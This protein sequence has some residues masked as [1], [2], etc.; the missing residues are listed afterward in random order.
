MDIQF[1]KKEINGMRKI[2]EENTLCI[3][4]LVTKKDYELKV[5]WISDTPIAFEVTYTR[6]YSNKWENGYID[7]EEETEIEFETLP[8]EQQA[9]ALKL[10]KNELRETI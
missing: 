2:S 3:Y 9:L 6:E 10:Y 8:I 4:T 7:E 1:T 5:E